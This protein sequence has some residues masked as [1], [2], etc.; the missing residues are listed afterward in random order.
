MLTRPGPW[1][2]ER[3][4]DPESQRDD[5]SHPLRAVVG[6]G[7]Y[8][9]YAVQRKWEDDAPASDVVVRELVAATREGHAAI[10]SYLLD[11]DLTATVSWELA[12]SDEPLWLALTDPRAVK[13]TLWDALW[14]RIVDL[15]AALTARKY[16]AD[17]DVVLEVRD[18]FCPWNEGRYRLAAGG[19]EPTADEPDLVLDAATLGAAY[20]GGTLLRDLAAAGRVEERTPGSLARA[21][22]A[23]R[24]DVA[25][26]CP[27]IF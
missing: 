3:L 22:A 25:P 7:A 10:C 1:W 17:P 20:L 27:E 21:S 8:A 13:R 4:H 6:D 14:I 2:D 18:G 11:L 16:G 9:V 15:P 5:N 26:W 12:P 24:G 23:F 19:C